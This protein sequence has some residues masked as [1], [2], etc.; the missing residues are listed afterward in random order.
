MFYKILPSSQVKESAITS[1][2]LG[3]YALPHELENDL[4]LKSGKSKNLLKYKLVPSLP[5]K[6]K[7][8]SILAKNF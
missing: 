1:N 7:I 5:A 2:K 3:M 8:F 4:R 6:M